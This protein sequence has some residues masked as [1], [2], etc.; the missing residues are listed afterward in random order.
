MPD[1]GDALNGRVPGS[2]SPRE[3]TF[4]EA[5]DAAVD[6]AVIVTIN[7]RL[8]RHLNEAYVG[9]RV[10]ASDSWW[11]TPS[12]LPLGSWLAALHDVA[13][14]SGASTRA[15]LPAT[16]AQ[17]RWATIIAKREPGLLDIDVAARGAFRAWRLAN[18]CR[19]LTEPDAHLTSDARAWRGWADAYGNSLD[20]DRRVDDAV[21]P[22][23]LIA[24]MRGK[25]IDLPSTVVFAGF[26]QTTPELFALQDG[27]AVAGADVAAVIGCEAGGRSASEID[28]ATWSDDAT[29]LEAVADAV[30]RHLKAKPDALLGVVVPDLDASRAAVR[31][32]FDQ[33]FFPACTPEQIEQIGRPYDLSV[34]E[35]LANTAVVRAALLLLRLVWRDLDRQAVST[36]LL[37]PHIGAFETEA[38]QREQLEFKLRAWRV[39]RLGL[40]ALRRRLGENS[41]LHGPL[42]ALGRRVGAAKRDG[43]EAVGLGEWAGRFSAALAAFGW[44]GDGRGS[45]EEQAVQSLHGVLDDLQSLDDGVPVGA[46]TALGEFTRLARQQ[47]FQPRTPALPISVLGRPESHGHRF[48]ALWVI[49]L[50]SDRWPASATPDPF[51]SIGMQ[52]DA[53]MPEASAEARL[54][55]ARRELSQW[56]CCAPSVALSCTRTRE[57]RPLEPSFAL[58]QPVEHPSGHGG[59]TDVAT[60]IRAAIGLESIDDAI[61]PAVSPGTA[62]RGGA[63][64]FRDQAECPF[65]AF[66]RHRLGVASLE[67]VDIGLDAR[68][69]GTLLHRALELFWQ[70]TVDHA[71]LM[72]LGTNALDESIRE[73]VE[74]AFDEDVF[75]EAVI[76]GLERQRVDTLLHEW[77]EGVEMNRVPFT[78]EAFEQRIDHVHRGIALRLTIDRIDCIDTE[79]GERR[80]VLDYKSGRS[81]GIDSW[82]NARIVSAQLPLYALANE[83]IEGVAIA[84]MARNACGFT[85]LAADVRLLPA[86]GTALSEEKGPQEWVGWRQHWR[87]SLDAVADEIAEGVAGVK[88]VPGACDYCDLK[89]LCRVGDVS[90]GAAD[91]DSTPVAGEVQSSSK[92]PEVT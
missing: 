84:R 9:R 53:G 16:V 91:M 67:E 69:V 47:L 24:L 35:A 49:G 13:L 12:I 23:H 83:A 15:R 70:R 76:G 57:G 32:A 85:G 42:Q 14:A 10:A 46:D 3:L 22:A 73:S 27:I 17:R 2:A 59:D 81:D 31:R 52:R 39:R 5:L 71:T 29:E 18:T 41:A 63:T 11:E 34:G 62:L 74:A 4:D 7:Q 78:V 88:P 72:S 58:F 48:D 37:S 19:C 40:W 28:C 6:G 44:P 56:R 45:E 77:I 54:A 51:L 79:S 61:A 43:R 30:F 68:R 21:L 55:L 26:L 25:H 36:V 66:A 65:R 82:V 87:D 92:G 38:R 33:R 80:V 50:D 90:S 64:L 1:V 86:V 8:S 89:P 20:A 60:R 75:L